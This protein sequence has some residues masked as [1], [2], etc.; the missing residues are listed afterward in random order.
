MAASP[1]DA[2]LDRLLQ[3]V[4]ESV[5][6]VHAC[7]DLEDDADC[8]ASAQITDEQ[9]AAFEETLDA[10]LQVNLRSKRF[11]GVRSRIHKLRQLKKLDVEYSAKRRIHGTS[12]N[13]SVETDDAGTIADEEERPL[14]HH[15]GC[16]ICKRRFVDLHHFYDQLCPSCAALNW[17]KRMAR[18]DLSGKVFLVTGARIKIGFECC[19]RLLECGA[20]VL[21]T[22]R[23]P[24]DCA[25]RFSSLPEFDDYQSRLHIYGID[26]RDLNATIRL[27]ERIKGEYSR[28]DGIVNNAAQT[29]RRPPAFYRHMMATE[30]DPRTFLSEAAMSTVRG[31]DTLRIAGAPQDGG[32]RPSTPM[33]A[34]LS[35]VALLDDDLSLDQYFPQHQF[36][37]NNQQ[38]DLRPKNSW[39]L[40]CHEVSPVELVEVFAVNVL[41]PFILNS[42]L[43]PLLL[44]KDRPDDM[45]F[46]VNVSAMEGKFY[47][48]K[49]PE[50]V[51][52]NMAK[53]ALNMLTRTSAI[54]F[55]RDRI[56]MNSVDTGW[57]NDENPFEKCVANAERNWATPIDEV[58]AM[59]RVLDPIIN[60]FANGV[61]PFGKFFKDFNET[62]W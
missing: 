57:I 21:A 53:A 32:F 4:Q 43:K 10:L 27:T 54:D 18:T 9:V 41:S 38:L 55:A 6:E 16:Y 47:R 62:E 1:G 28:L 11:R 46:I 17:S 23:F 42:R 26:L 13:V 8:A 61:V 31:D 2:A 59:A 58:D 56:Y 34:V 48:F 15:R 3:R 37:V 36:D 49:G 40:L 29:V 52:T 14:F 22:T 51:H 33:S 20:T 12:N 44:Q 50:H 7:S 24:M 45:K 5:P 35:Q 60:G 30:S 25:K 39:T 19:K